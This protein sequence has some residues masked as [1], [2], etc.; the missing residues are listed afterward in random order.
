MKNTVV[1]LWAADDITRL[2]G[3]ATPMTPRYVVIMD[4]INKGKGEK[5]AFVAAIPMA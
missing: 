5:F 4:V 3:R 2:K 1:I